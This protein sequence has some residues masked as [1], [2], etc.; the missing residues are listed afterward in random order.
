[1]KKYR[2]VKIQ[3]I[4]GAKWKVQKKSI[5]G[6]WYNYPLNIDVLTTDA[7]TTGVYSSYEGAKNFIDCLLHKPKSEVVYGVNNTMSSQVCA[8]KQYKKFYQSLWCRK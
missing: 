4:D 2:I 5:F 6:F 3:C 1:M 7:F 8:R